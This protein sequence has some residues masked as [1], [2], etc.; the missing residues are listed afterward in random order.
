MRHLFR[1]ALAGAA[2][3]LAG[4]CADAASVDYS[5]SLGDSGNP[6][7]FGSDRGAPDFTDAPYNNVA[8][9]QVDV[10]QAGTLTISSAGFGDGHLDPYVTLFSGA[11]H[12]A[13]F[14]GSAQ[15][16]FSWSLPVAAGWYWVAIG[17]WENFS[18]A[19]NLGS[20]TLA[21]GFIGIGDPNYYADGAYSVTVS[22]DTGTPP[23]PEPSPSALLAL[24]LVALG[25][26]AWR[27]RR[28]A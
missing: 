1:N 10:T 20:G 12:G 25:T 6:Y 9:Y 18:F 11:D 5:G 8:L 23:I 22:L 26:R 21:D 14:V 7:L 17:D 13:V 19:E 28:A 3:A 4:I 16:D 24:G 15:D 2:L 27:G